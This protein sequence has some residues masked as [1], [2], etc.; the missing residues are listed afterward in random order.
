MSGT[1]PV[2][3]RVLRLRYLHPG[4]LLCFLFFEGSIALGV[5]LALAELAPWWGMVVLPVAVALMV[6]LNDTVAAS[7][8]QMVRVAPAHVKARPGP[9]VR[10]SVPTVRPSVPHARVAD[11]PPPASRMPTSGEPAGAIPSDPPVPG[12]SGGGTGRR[13]A[14]ERDTRSDL[15]RGPNQRRFE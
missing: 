4:G 2:Y 14:A 5:L 10:P 15:R 12:R 9:I 1:R 13:V 8:A 11:P 6:K 3:A 7:H